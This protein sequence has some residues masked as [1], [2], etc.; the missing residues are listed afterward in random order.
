MSAYPRHEITELLTK[1]LN[2]LAEGYRQNIAIIGNERIGKTH[3]IHYFLSKYSNNYVIPIYVEAKQEEGSV[4]LQRFI[5]TLLYA[6]LQNSGIKLSPDIDFLIR[7]TKNY[8]PQ[9]ALICEEIL[10]EPK[11]KQ[12]NLTKLFQLSE[13]IFEETGKRCCIILDEFHRLSELNIKDF[14]PNWRK[15][16]MLNKN[17]QYILISSK[18]QLANKILSNDLN[19]LF[20]NFHKIELGPLDMPSAQQLIHDIFPQISINE[21]LRDFIIDFC[22]Q[23]PFY[24]NTMCAALRDYHAKEKN[25][26]PSVN[27][28]MSAIE[29]MFFEELGVINKIFSDTLKQIQDNVKKQKVTE[30]LTMIGEGANRLPELSHKLCQ[31]KKEIKPLVEVLI[32]QDVI[33]KASD[34]Y[35]LND[36]LFGFWLRCVHKERVNSYSIDSS[37]LKNAFEKEITGLYDNFNTARKKCV[38]ERILELFN[39][40]ADESVQVEKKTLRLNHFKEVKLLSI[41]GRNIKEGI[42]GRGSN[43]LWIAAL[44]EGA[45]VEDDIFEFADICKKFKYNKTQKKVLITLGVI[46][47]NARLVA[48]EQKILTWDISC[49][50]SLFEIYGKPRIVK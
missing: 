24:L 48:K 19:L 20:G 1:R 45:I 22:G 43:I 46:D 29:S 32:F 44:K 36:R 49:L 3:L 25:T 16:L 41:N 50:N 4:F 33:S 31:P 17:T 40:F 5:G 47:V 35:L 7:K 42:L 13:T 11:K 23:S 21:P 28:L 8:A 12:R 27:T 18:K 30:L 10:N 2:S 34:I 15:F 6:F 9:T 26:V 37:R 38:S 14:Y 39:Q